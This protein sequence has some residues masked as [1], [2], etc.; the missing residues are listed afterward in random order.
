MSSGQHGECVVY[1]FGNP[2]GEALPGPEILQTY[3]PLNH[4]T[5]GRFRLATIPE[6]DDCYLRWCEPWTPVKADNFASAIQ[7]GQ[8]HFQAL[9]DESEGLLQVPAHRSWEGQYPD[10]DPRRVG[11]PAVMSVVEKIALAEPISYFG[12]DSGIV[13]YGLAK[14][15][16]WVCRTD[17]PAQLRDIFRLNQYTRGVGAGKSSQL[18]MP[19]I[20]LL[21]ESTQFD[22]FT[23]GTSNKLHTLQRIH[24]T[25]R[26]NAPKR[27][28][29]AKLL[30][31]TEEIIRS[32]QKPNMYF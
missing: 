31:E 9:I 7:T 19:D 23:S 17:Q 10:V 27:A 25:L 8:R 30:T 20:D 18:H 2:T 16:N 32:K 24:D 26:I 11:T 13:V 21:L 6:R 4:L 5:L 3:N 12:R 29:S 1:N 28:D 22:G 14:Y 15:L